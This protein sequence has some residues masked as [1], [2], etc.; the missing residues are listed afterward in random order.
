MSKEQLAGSLSRDLAAASKKRAPASGVER[1]K[2]K[3]SQGG[4]NM[5]PTRQ[6]QWTQ[7]FYECRKLRA[8]FAGNLKRAAPS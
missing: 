1:K 2:K 6:S 8:I 5:S 4:S 7:L 3:D